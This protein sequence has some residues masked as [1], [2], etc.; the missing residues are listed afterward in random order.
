VKVGMKIACEWL[1]LVKTPN[2]ESNPMGENNTTL[3]SP[4]L[5]EYVCMKKIF[6]EKCLP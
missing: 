1:V 2:R 5:Y 3:P 6:R 4:S